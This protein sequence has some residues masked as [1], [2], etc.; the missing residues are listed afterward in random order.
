MVL[1]NC[2]D[3]LE[4]RN[5]GAIAGRRPKIVRANRAMRHPKSQDRQVRCPPAATSRTFRPSRQKYVHPRFRSDRRAVHRK[6]NRRRAV[7]EQLLEV[8]RQTAPAR[9]ADH[10]SPRAREFS[11]SHRVATRCRRTRALGQL[12]RCSRA[13]QARACFAHE[14]WG[15]EQVIHMPMRYKNSINFGR[16]MFHR[17]V[18]AMHVWL[19]SRSKGYPRKIDARKIRIDKKCVS[20]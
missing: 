1:K 7:A 11:S 14:K 10:V 20:S 18:D 3:D 5:A 4:T 16:E 17:V 13:D 6:P 19:N 9:K 15:V 12:H 8:P 2:L